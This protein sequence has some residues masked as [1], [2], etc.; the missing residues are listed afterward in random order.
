MRTSPLVNL[1]DAAVLSILLSAICANG[2]LGQTAADPPPY[3]TLE[4][5]G[6]SL[7]VQRVSSPGRPYFAILNISTDRGAADFGLSRV[8]LRSFGY[9]WGWAKLGLGGKSWRA[10]KP[11]G[12]CGIDSCRSVI[13]RTGRMIEMTITAEQPDYGGRAATYRFTLEEVK[14]MDRGVDAVLRDAGLLKPVR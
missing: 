10:F 4:Q 6:A 3:V 14:A 13:L 11:V 12:S 2:A 5:K 7:K 8:N 1:T 9:T